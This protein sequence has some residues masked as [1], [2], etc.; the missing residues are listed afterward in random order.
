MVSF[1]LSFFEGFWR[2][3]WPKPFV[4]LEPRG[5]K[6]TMLVHNLCKTF[7]RQSVRT[8]STQASS[9]KVL[10]AVYEQNGHPQKVV[11]YVL[12]RPRIAFTTESPTQFFTEAKLYVRIKERVLEPVG[13]GQ[14]QVRMLFA[15]INP[16]DLNMIQGSYPIHPELPAVGG[17]EG[18]GRVVSVGAG[19]SKFRV[20]DLV[21]P[22]SPSLGTSLASKFL[23]EILCDSFLLPPIFVQLNHPRFAKTWRSEFQTLGLSFFLGDFETC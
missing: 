6:E 9:T 8:Y 5:R 11:Q 14:V 12:N 2:V 21:I 3:F 7:T 15:P 4:F 1:S 22:V 18:V 13:A 19:V 10:E 23:R 17:N 16:A 20:G